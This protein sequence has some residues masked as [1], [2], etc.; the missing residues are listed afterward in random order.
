VSM[1]TVTVMK[2]PPNV[3]PRGEEVIIENISPKSK[4]STTVRISDCVNQ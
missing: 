3:P 2:Q 4:Y 1:K